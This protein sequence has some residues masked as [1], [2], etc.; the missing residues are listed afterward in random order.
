MLP[1][2]LVLFP[3]NPLHPTAPSRRKPGMPPAQGLRLDPRAGR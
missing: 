3:S 1:A 2:P